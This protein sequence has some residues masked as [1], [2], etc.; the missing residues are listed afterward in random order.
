VVTV[1]GLTTLFYLVQKD[2]SSAIARATITT[3]LQF[4]KIAPVDQSTIEQA[5]TLDYLNFE[6]AVQ[7][8]SAMQVK[9]DC[10]IPRNGKD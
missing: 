1:G 9:A 10:L 8:I 3:L 5:L 6:D 7:M 4:I 2:K